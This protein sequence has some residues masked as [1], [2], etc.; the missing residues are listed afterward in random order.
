MK[1]KVEKKLEDKKIDYSF[2][3]KCMAG[4]AAAAVVTAGVLAV[5]AATT[6]NPIGVGVFAAASILGPI[7]ALVGLALLVAA[8]CLIPCLPGV[9]RGHTT[10]GPGYRSCGLFSG[11]GF[12]RTVNYT[13]GGRNPHLNGFG[14]HTHTH[15]GSIFSTNTHTHGSRVFGHGGLGGVHSRS[16]Q[17]GGVVHHHR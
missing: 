1:S 13:S 6:S 15:N 17:S 4:L 9:G 12:P 16:H 10:Y 11:F 5:V 3:L 2:L 14:H 7:G 8:A